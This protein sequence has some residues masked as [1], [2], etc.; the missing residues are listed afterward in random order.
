MRIGAERKPLVCRPHFLK[1]GGLYVI[2]DYGIAPHASVCTGTL[3]ESE[4][5]LETVEQETDIVLF[6]TGKF[7]EIEVP[8]CNVID[9]PPITNALV[10]KK[11]RV[12]EYITKP[13]KDLIIQHY[14]AA[15][16]HD[17]MGSVLIDYDLTFDTIEHLTNYVY[18]NQEN[19]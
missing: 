17:N 8:C 16:C 13:T 4:D 9:M 14:G 19:V 3:L 10:G 18:D 11:V 6:L 12:K 15:C 1:S 2:Y 5:D 7:G